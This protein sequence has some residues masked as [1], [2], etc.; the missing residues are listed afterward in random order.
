[1]CSGSG[2]DFCW[3]TVQGLLFGNS[4]G[5]G[6]IDALEFLD[7]C[8]AG[9]ARSASIRTLQILAAIDETRTARSRTAGVS[10][11]QRFGKVVRLLRMSGVP[12]IT[13]AAIFAELEL[14]RPIH[15]PKAQL[16]PLGAARPIVQG[17]KS[18]NGASY[19][20]SPYQL[21]PPH[22]T[23][24]NHILVHLTFEGIAQTTTMSSAK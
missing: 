4:A 22:P 19:H 23:R 20:G 1:M 14:E 12:I 5:L 24:E 18:P 7:C 11:T 16:K 10:F 15:T 21:H 9:A 6:H 17:F 13:T 8:S 3:A 2:K